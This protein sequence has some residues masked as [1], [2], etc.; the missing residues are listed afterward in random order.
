MLHLII[1]AMAIFLSVGKLFI[2]TYFAVGDIMQ[3]CVACAW[4]ATAEPLQTV[5]Y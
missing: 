1:F 2:F 4:V 3:F 5:L